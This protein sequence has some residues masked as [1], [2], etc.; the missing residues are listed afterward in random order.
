MNTVHVR[1]RSPCPICIGADQQM[2]K[3]IALLEQD[4]VITIGELRPLLDGLR[5]HRPHLDLQRLQIRLGKREEPTYSQLIRDDF[6]FALD[7]KQGSNEADY[8][9]W[10]VEELG[11]QGM[12][13]ALG[14]FFARVRNDSHFDKVT[15][16]VMGDGTKPIKIDEITKILDEQYCNEY[17]PAMVRYL[18]RLLIDF[19]NV[20][21]YCQADTY[22][23]L[24]QLPLTFECSTPPEV[25]T[26]H[27]RPVTYL[28]SCRMIQP[29]IIIDSINRYYYGV[30][31]SIVE[32]I[33]RMP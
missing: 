3:R 16:I 5:H 18:P 31:T 2:R 20:Q 33:K 24:A 17:V 1:S 21:H 27:P 19:P 11:T 15:T 8:E 14:F 12:S 6:W 10:M 28:C 29:P 9:H 7:V 22:G 25:Y 23:P 13:S 26:F 30:S 4:P 32:G